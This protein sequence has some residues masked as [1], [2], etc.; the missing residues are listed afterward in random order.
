MSGTEAEPDGAGGRHGVIFYDSASALRRAFEGLAAHRPV[1]LACGTGAAGLWRN[2]PGAKV[3]AI[4]APQMYPR[5]ASLTA[6]FLRA[7]ARQASPIPPMIIVERAGRHT[8]ETSYEWASSEAAWNTLAGMDIWCLYDVRTT[9]PDLLSL[10]RHTHPWRENDGSRPNAAYA[11]ELLPA[12]PLPELDPRRALLTRSVNRRTEQLQAPKELADILLRH[13]VPPFVVGDL[14]AAVSEVIANVALHGRTPATMTVWLGRAGIDVA[15]S[16]SGAGFDDSSAGRTPPASDRA[17]VGLWLARQTCDRLTYEVR[18]GRFTV[19]LHTALPA[20]DPPGR[21]QGVHA[22][23]HAARR[24]L[25][26]L[27]VRPR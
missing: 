18:P 25:D 13:Q 5:P 26:R 22:R 15:V 2:M 16:D 24:R 14:Y 9:A 11:D 17:E 23:S 1:I 12:P 4:V 7:A 6:A 27:A 3:S 21:V 20:A 8:A 19:R 10:A